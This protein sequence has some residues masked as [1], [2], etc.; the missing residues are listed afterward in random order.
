MVGLGVVRGSVCEVGA[1]NGYFHACENRP[2]L[3]AQ[4]VYLVR[5][6]V[7]LPIVLP[8][9]VRRP[10][11]CGRSDALK[12]IIIAKFLM[13]RYFKKALKNPIK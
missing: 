7:V 9:I 8:D 1:C 3:S 11:L 10:H 13:K 4:G 12:I 2:P 6:G 5:A